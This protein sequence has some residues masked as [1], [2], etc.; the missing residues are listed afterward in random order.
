MINLFT[1]LSFSNVAIGQLYQYFIFALLASI[2]LFSTWLCLRRLSSFIQSKD[3]FFRLFTGFLI[4]ILNVGLFFVFLYMTKHSFSTPAIWFPIFSVTLHVVDQLAHTFFCGSILTPSVSN[5]KV[6]KLML[7]M[8]FGYGLALTAAVICYFLPQTQRFVYQILLQRNILV[9]S[10]NLI[11]LTFTLA[12]LLVIRFKTD[13]FLLG[14]I[15]CL[16][17]ATSF[18]SL[19]ILYPFIIKYLIV[20]NLLQILAF[21][22]IE[23]YIFFEII[24]E[25]SETKEQVESLNTDLESRIKDRT[26]ELFS[27]NKDLFHANYMLHQEKEKLNTIIENLEEGI[28]V[29]NVN[30]KLLM[31]NSSAKKLL[32]LDDHAIGQS[33]NEIIPDKGYLSD[34]N[35][36]ILKKIRV[37]SKEIE[38]IHKEEARTRVYVQIKSSL[39]T[40]SKGNIIGLITLLRDI[41]KEIE[42]EQVK[43]GFLKTMS[44]ELK[45]PLTTIIGFTETL[46]AERRG[47]LNENQ[48]HFTE[49]ILKESLH[50]S[51]L[52]ND[53]LEF[54]KVTADKISLVYEE[55]NLK[56]LLI[57][58]VDSYR[59]QADVKNIELVVD[60]SFTLPLIQA[61]KDKLSKAFLNIIANAIYYTEKGSVSI[62]FYTDKNKLITKVSDTG[63]GIA[64]ENME[65]IFE[66]FNNIKNPLRP[67]QGKS[68]LGLGLSIARDLIALHDGRIWVES[69]LGEGSSFYIELPVSC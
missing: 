13:P 36:I 69:T 50:L 48:K 27:S 25:L 63:M 40:D 41:S 11:F 68:G 3:S 55:V 65:K 17:L 23:I 8:G 38:L 53:L 28:L 35:Q 4:T 12:S 2:G 34:I 5:R 24:M 47:S 51:K 29:S 15:I 33:L 57:G 60:D 64:Q 10:Y 18:Q 56:A 22:L 14:G 21:L 52:I 16:F 49:I 67:E 44:H 7:V 46:A 39:S 43:S 62:S 58:I 19:S 20:Y 66:K 30:S 9:L 32:G 6:H 45:T 26:Q 31:I 61:D 1:Y 42:I 59:P 37:V 54:T